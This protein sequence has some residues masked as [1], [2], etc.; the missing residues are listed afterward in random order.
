MNLIGLKDLHGQVSNVSLLVETYNFAGYENTTGVPVNSLYLNLR[1]RNLCNHRDYQVSSL[2][3]SFFCLLVIVLCSNI[4]YQNV[5]V[6]GARSS[7]M[8]RSVMKNII[9]CFDPFFIFSD[10]IHV[11][12]EITKQITLYCLC[13]N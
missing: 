2:N 7:S 10:L 5:G 13:L 4:P 12:C 8:Y 6:N 3:W 1:Q 9:N 11:L